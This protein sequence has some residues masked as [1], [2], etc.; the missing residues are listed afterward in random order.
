MNEGQIKTK[1]FLIKAADYLLLIA[2]FC[3]AIYTYLNPQNINMLV[4]IILIGLFILN[5]VG[6]FTL[7][8]IALLRIELEKLKREEKAQRFNK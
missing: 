1:I 6:H 7:A 8:K 4:T 2:I 3:I 5:R